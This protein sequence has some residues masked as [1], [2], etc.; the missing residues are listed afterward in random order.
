MK[1]LVMFGIIL[2]KLL[3]LIPVLIISNFQSRHK[4]TL[5][6]DFKN[7]KIIAL[8]EFKLF[9]LLGFEFKYQEFIFKSIQFEL[10]PEKIK[11]SLVLVFSFRNF[12]Y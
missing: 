2:I 3:S 5:R 8:R 1:L 11:I 6:Y 12:Q 10:K 4:R 9:L 7:F